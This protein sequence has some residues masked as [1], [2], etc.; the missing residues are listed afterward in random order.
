MSDPR[1]NEVV[2]EAL[3]KLNLEG[4]QAVEEIEALLHERMGIKPNL[5]IAMVVSP[6]DWDDPEGRPTI[7]IGSVKAETGAVMFMT[8]AQKLA[9]TQVDAIPPVVKTDGEGKKKLDGE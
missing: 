2:I 6:R 1:C 5:A 8:A 7:T 9:A 4:Q 3:H